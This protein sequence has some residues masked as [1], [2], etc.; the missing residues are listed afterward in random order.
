M[1]RLRSGMF[2]ALAG[3]VLLTACFPPFDALLPPPFGYGGLVPGE[4]GDEPLIVVN[5]TDDDWILSFGSYSGPAAYAV[6]AG[7]TGKAILFGEPTG[8]VQLLDRA[9]GEVDRLD[10][11]PSFGALVIEPPGAVRGLENVAS[12]EA[13]SLI[14]YWDCSFGDAW[15]PT[16]HDRLQGGTGSI[17]LDGAAGGT[18]VLDVASGEVGALFDGMSLEDEVSVSPDGARVA[19]TRISMDDMATEVVLA[20]IDGSGARVLAENGFG[21]TFS[22]DGTQLAFVEF[23]PFAGGGALTVVDVDGGEPVRIASGVS[24]ARWSPDGSMLAFTTT[25]PGSQFGGDSIEPSELQVIRPDGTGLRT[26][27]QGPADAPPPAWSPD[28]TRIAFTGSKGDQPLDGETTIDIVT[29]AEGTVRTVAELDGAA[30]SEPMWSPDGRRLAFGTYEFE[31]LAHTSGIG[32]VGVDG[33]AVDMLASGQGAF[34]GGPIWSPDGR[35]I[36]TV[37]VADVELSAELVAFEVASG[38]ETVLASEVLSVTAWLERQL[39]D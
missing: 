10:W 38:Q 9:C 14:E 22:P 23:D 5:E 32:I 25:E 26:L 4:M 8:P 12:D 33:G 16:P 31:L 28:G 24:V 2:A 18:W 39:L 3:S 21:P 1:V 17:L 29:V 7:A 15:P 36:A 37:R 13:V 34:Y 6:P 20:P 27:A 19:F 35:W 11:D 30:L